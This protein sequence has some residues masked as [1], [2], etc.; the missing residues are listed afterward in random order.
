MAEKILLIDDNEDMRALFSHYLSRRGYQIAE[1]E[2]GVI[3]LEK[4]LTYNP[5]LIL[6]DVI[7]PNSDGYETCRKIKLNPSI[8]DIP[9]IFLS[10]LT[11]TKDKLQGFEAGGAD[12]FT[13][14]GELQELLARVQAHLKIRSL[15]NSLT[16]AIAGLREKQRSLDEDIASAATIQ[17]TLLP[18]QEHFKM[19]E[20]EIAWKFHPCNFI[21]GD[22]FNVLR[23]DED[24][25]AFYILDVSGHGVPSAMVAVSI[26]QH[27]QELINLN[28]SGQSEL[29]KAPGQLMRDLDREFPLMRFDKY[30]TIFYMVINHKTRNLIYSSAGHPPA[31]LLHKD[32]SYDLLKKGGSILGVDSQIPFEEE[33]IQLVDGDRII[34]YTDGVYEFEDSKEKFFGME[35]FLSL[36]EDN[37]HDPVNRIT[38][39]IF[40]TL[41]EFGGNAP[42]KDDIS[43]MAISISK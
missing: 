26:S 34:L 9:I 2:D 40:Q 17:R 22:I 6:M 20:I 36:V 23:I 3:G 16:E 38:E 33:S 18:L 13:K 21:G 42:I 41:F 39:K 4:A 5:D 14:S 19:S 31:I 7:M 10:S 25:V 11:E 15:N 37:K 28:H 35:R 43:L 1:A 29:L 32:K 30:F 8:K 12:F 24:R 27:F